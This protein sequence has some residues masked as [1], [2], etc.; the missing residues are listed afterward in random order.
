MASLKFPCQHSG[1][2][3][4]LI[5][6][7]EHCGGIAYRLRSPDKSPRQGN[8]NKTQHSEF[9]IQN[10]GKLFTFLPFE[11]ASAKETLSKESFHNIKSLFF[12]EISY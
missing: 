11:I 1:I 7:E 4:T 10:W 3:F 12:K 2:I 6:G 9:S 8:E 5:H